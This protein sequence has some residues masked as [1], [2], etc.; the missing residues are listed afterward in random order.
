MNATYGSSGS[1]FSKVRSKSIGH[2]KYTGRRS[3]F[4]SNPTLIHGPDNK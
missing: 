3:N 4:R 2:K 1:F